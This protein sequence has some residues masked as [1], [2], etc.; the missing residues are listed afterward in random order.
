[1]AWTALLKQVDRR[2]A[3]EN[4]WE[5]RAQASSASRLERYIADIPLDRF[6]TAGSGFQ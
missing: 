4:G 1:M 3:V 6:R 2:A 5:W